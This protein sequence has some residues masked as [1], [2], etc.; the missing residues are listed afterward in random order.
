M[1]ISLPGEGCDP[2]FESLDLSFCSIVVQAFC[3]CVDLFELSVRISAFSSEVFSEAF[4]VCEDVRPAELENESCFSCQAS[5]DRMP[6]YNKGV[7]LLLFPEKFEGYFCFSS[8][9]DFI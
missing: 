8:S 2:F 6:V 3:I 9:R 4:R 5:E 1:S 7:S